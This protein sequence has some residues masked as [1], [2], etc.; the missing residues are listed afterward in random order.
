MEYAFFIW[1][2][3]I[4]VIFE[5]LKGPTYYCL[6]LIYISEELFVMDQYLETKNWCYLYDKYS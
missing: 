1:M 5:V 6:V 3:E 4:W 2:N